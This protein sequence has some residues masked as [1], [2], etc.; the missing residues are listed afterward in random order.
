MGFI[1]C[2]ICVALALIS[3]CIIASRSYMIFLLLKKYIDSK[4][5][6]EYSYKEFKYFLVY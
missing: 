3:F 2:P 5:E 4:A 6:E 1:H